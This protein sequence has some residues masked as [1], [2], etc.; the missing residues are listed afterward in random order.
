MRRFRVA[1]ASGNPPS[2]TVRRL[3]GLQR[4]PWPEGQVMS[5]LDDGTKR[6]SFEADVMAVDELHAVERI[7]PRLL[8]SIA[9]TAKNAPK[10]LQ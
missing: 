3:V 5:V 2:L 6:W 10:P 1:L 4:W 9:E 7:A 8:L